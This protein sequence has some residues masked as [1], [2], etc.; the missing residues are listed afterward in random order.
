MD[1][2]RYEWTQTKPYRCIR[3]KRLRFFTLVPDVPQRNSWKKC[4]L[5]FTS[6][7]LLKKMEM[8]IFSFCSL[9]YAKQKWTLFALRSLAEHSQM[10]LRFK[11]MTKGMIWRPCE[12]SFAVT[13]MI[14]DPR[15]KPS[16][17]ICK[18]SFRIIHRVPASHTI[19]MRV[20]LSTETPW[21]HTLHCEIPS[22]GSVVALHWNASLGTGMH[23]V[24]TSDRPGF[25]S[26]RG[27]YNTD[28]DIQL[29]QCTHYSFGLDRLVGN[30]CVKRQIAGWMLDQLGF[31][32]WLTESSCCSYPIQPT[33]GI[34]GCLFVTWLQR[35][36]HISCFACVS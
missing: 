15:L 18:Q 17:K 2:E 22:L 13:F 10:C 27:W 16:N 21:R 30:A 1:T 9:P 6:S 29:E 19:I 8:K 34:Y 25:S 4:T 3:G 20:I 26:L 33:V 11:S 7:S 14:I 35:S 24:P 12:D 36:D 31:R 32:E 23:A 28:S 5:K